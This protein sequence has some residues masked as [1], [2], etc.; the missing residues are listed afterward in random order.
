MPKF[1]YKTRVDR[2]DSDEEFDEVEP[3]GSI[4]GKPPKEVIVT[5]RDLLIYLKDSYANQT[6]VYCKQALEINQE[7]NVI[8]NDPIKLLVTVASDKHI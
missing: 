6:L 2:E 4:I 3:L 5:E 8:V 1:K 7:T